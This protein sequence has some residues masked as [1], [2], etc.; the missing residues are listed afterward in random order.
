[1]AESVVHLLE[2]IQVTNDDPAGIPVPGGAAQL[3]LRPGL[4]GVPVG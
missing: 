1:M 2:V 3:A 4:Y